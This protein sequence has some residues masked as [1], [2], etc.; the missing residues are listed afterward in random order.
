MAVPDLS[1][2]TASPLGGQLNALPE[3]PRKL[4]QGSERFV[5][6]EAHPLATDSGLAADRVP[7]VFTEH[8]WLRG[9]HDA[10]WKAPTLHILSGPRAD[11]CAP[12]CCF[13]RF[14]LSAK[15]P[16]QARRWPRSSGHWD[17]EKLM[18]SLP[19]QS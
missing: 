16:L 6:P 12:R 5:W 18:R 10:S 19:S 8:L 9:L 3:T 14:P 17:Q 2:H 1:P 7:R 13:S 15:Q 11:V 4:R